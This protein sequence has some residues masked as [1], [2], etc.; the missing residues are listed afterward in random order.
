MEMLEVDKK[1]IDAKLLSCEDREPSVSPGLN[2]LFLNKKE[3]KHALINFR[4]WQLQRLIIYC[5]LSTKMCQNN[6]RQR[7]DKKVII[8]KSNSTACV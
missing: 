4:S 8:S 7:P 2:Q 1:N 5:L 6:Q 3:R